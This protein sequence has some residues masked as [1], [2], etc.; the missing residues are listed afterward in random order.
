MSDSVKIGQDS[1]C[2]T[3]EETPTEDQCVQCFVCKVMFHAY[4][5]QKSSDENYGTKTMV[6][7]F[8]SSSTK[9]NFKFFCDP[10]ATKMERNM[11]QTEGYKI[12]ILENK[13][14]SV[15]KK[16]DEM[17]ELMKKTTVLKKPL[18]EKSSRSHPPPCVWD[19]KERLEFCEF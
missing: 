17:M 9:D 10:C 13:V 12:K 8:H 19:D 6:K 1:A 3:C 11:K 14:S 15:E 5:E 7:T 16:L 4:C 2:P 18:E